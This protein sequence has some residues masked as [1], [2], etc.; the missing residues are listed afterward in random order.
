[1]RLPKSTYRASTVLGL[2]VL[3]AVAACGKEEEVVDVGAGQPVVEKLTP[4]P[5]GASPAER[6]GFV[7]R[8]P[9][10]DPAGRP[11]LDWTAPGEWK[12]LPPV[13]MRLVGFQVGGDANAEC[14]LAVFAGDTGGVLDNVN[15]W[16]QQM[17]L[18]PVEAAALA[19]MPKKTLLGG[20][21][22]LV[23]L[24]GHYVG[25]RGSKDL[26]DAKLVGVVRLLPAASVF[27]KLVGPAKVVDAEAARF[28][29]FCASIR[30]AGAAAASPTSEAPRDP[31]PPPG[32]TP[33]PTPTPTPTPA[34]T[35]AAPVAGSTGEANGLRWKWPAG[36][37][38]LAN[39]SSMRAATLVVD[40]APDVDISL[41]ILSKNSGGLEANLNR[42]QGQMGR[43]ALSADEI[44][45]LPRV[46][47][48]GTKAVIVSIDGTYTSMGGKTTENATMRGAII[49]RENDVVFVKATG[50][51]SDVAKLRSAFDAFVASLE[52]TDGVK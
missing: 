21:G 50:P 15:R 9:V 52:S 41:T 5:K 6:L 51:A 39:G 42:W 37:S 36:W 26:G 48:L 49:E 34:P 14:T 43:P 12:E 10:G 22:T 27:V 47:S 46:P 32:P 18:D 29:A 38:H 2:V 33:A 16:R 19:S 1:M 24:A 7:M 28:D 31:P 20:D 25:M 11:M 30:M 40:I 4:A 45:A 8:K 17:S 44:A 35:K 3:C 13:E 23:E